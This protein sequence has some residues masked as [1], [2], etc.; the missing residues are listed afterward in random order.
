M[1]A[2]VP[3]APLA[4]V[5]ACHSISRIRTVPL[6]VVHIQHITIDFFSGHLSCFKFN[7]AKCR[8]G[9]AG[10]I[11][12]ETSR[13]RTLRIEFQFRE[14]PTARVGLF[15]QCP[16]LKSLT[17]NQVSR[18]SDMAFSKLLLV[19]NYSSPASSSRPNPRMVMFVFLFCHIP[20]FV[21]FRPSARGGSA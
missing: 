7:H 6:C 1:T 17:K 4:V 3:N 12:Q 11:F 15:F 10:R 8:C 5:F 19:P 13:S 2:S 21:Y 20:F 14:Q 9:S 16:A 18:H